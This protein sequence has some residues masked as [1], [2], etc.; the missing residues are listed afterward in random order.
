MFFGKT[1]NANFLT[2]TLCGVDDKQ[3]NLFRNGKKET[4]GC[5]AAGISDTNA[6]E[7]GIFFFSEVILE[8]QKNLRN[9]CSQ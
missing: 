4:S 9:Q 8:L 6:I 7:L 5:G 1:L 2:Y 3:R